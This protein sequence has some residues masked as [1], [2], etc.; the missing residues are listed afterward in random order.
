MVV[1][2]NALSVSAPTLDHMS[3]CKLGIFIPQSTGRIYGKIRFSQ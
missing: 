1:V 3:H 2:V